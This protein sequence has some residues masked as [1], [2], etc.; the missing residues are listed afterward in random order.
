[1]LRKKTNGVARRSQRTSILSQAAT[2]S[3]DRRAFLRGSGL[4]IG[5]LSA[6]AATGGTVTRADAATTAVGAVDLRKTVCTH[7]S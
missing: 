4:M 3:V 1:M 2:A 5:G 6:I 7:C